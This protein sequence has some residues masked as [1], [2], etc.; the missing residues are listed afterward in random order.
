[1][2]ERFV[3]NPCLSRKGHSA[4][5]LQR[6]TS[7]SD[8]VSCA[9]WLLCALLLGTMPGLPAQTGP[10]TEKPLPDLQSILTGMAKHNQ[11]RDHTLQTYSVDRI[12]KV[13]NKRFN[14]SAEVVARMIFVAPGEKLFEIHS[15]AGTGFMRKGVINRI[16]ETEQ[17]NAVPD[18]QSKSAISPDNYTFQLLGREVRKGREQYV[19]HAKPRRKDL[20]LFDAKIW[21]DAED[22]AVTRIE[23]RPAKNPS[24]WTRKVDFTHEYE[25][26]GPYWMPVRNRSMTQVFIFGQTTTEI[27]YSNYQINKPELAERAAEIRRRGDKLEIQIDSKDKK[28]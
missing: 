5:H 25:K 6:R 11:F 24:F 17:K 19:L 9:L 13:E 8:H 10:S 3:V 12:Y 21:V 7:A 2:N 4:P 23:G 20:L 18:Q 22:F 1:M 16:I 28:Q 26:F 14:K 27:V 15:T